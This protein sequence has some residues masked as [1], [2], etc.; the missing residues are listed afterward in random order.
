MPRNADVSPRDRFLQGPERPVPPGP[1]GPSPAGLRR[2]GVRLGPHV[3]GYFFVALGSGLLGLVVASRGAPPLLPLTSSLVPRVV[4]VPIVAEP[5][6]PP[7]DEEDTDFERDMRACRLAIA[8]ALEGRCRA[9][10]DELNG[11][12]GYLRPTALANVKRCRS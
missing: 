7:D 8:A 12:W 5:S 6:A 2:P 3:F 9:A 11:C 10:R 1:R 4:V